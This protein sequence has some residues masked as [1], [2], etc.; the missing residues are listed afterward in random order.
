MVAIVMTLSVLEGHFPVASL[1][2]CI[3]RGPSARRGSCLSSRNEYVAVAHINAK[4]D[5][6]TQTGCRRCYMIN[7][8]ALGLHVQCYAIKQF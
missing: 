7:D 1:F 3:A 8:L 4:D 6:N 2:K 5:T